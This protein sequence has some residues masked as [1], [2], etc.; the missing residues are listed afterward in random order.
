MAS[1][2]GVV[3]ICFH[4]SW[5]DISSIPLSILSTDTECAPVLDLGYNA[6]RCGPLTGGAQAASFK[7]GSGDPVGDALLSLV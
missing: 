6:G 1:S 2:L 5:S 7:G 3:G 4:G